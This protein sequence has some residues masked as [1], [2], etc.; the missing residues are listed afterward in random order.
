MPLILGEAVRAAADGEGLEWEKKK[1][2]GH[3]SLG[4]ESCLNKAM[5]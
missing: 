5:L 1:S 3:G 2:E 4:Q